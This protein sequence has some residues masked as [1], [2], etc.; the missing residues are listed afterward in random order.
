MVCKHFFSDQRDFTPTSGEGAVFVYENTTLPSLNLYPFPTRWFNFRPFRFQSLQIIPTRVILLI[1]YSFRG[2]RSVFYAGDQ[3]VVY[4][5]VPA[6]KM[7]LVDYL[8]AGAKTDQIGGRFTPGFVVVKEGVNHRMP[9]E[10]R[11]GFGQVDDRVQNR[12]VD[13]QSFGMFQRKISEEIHKSFEGDH[14]I[15]TVVDGGDMF[16]RGA[17]FE[18][19]GAQLSPSG[20]VAETDGEKGAAVYLVTDLA[21]EC[22]GDRRDDAARGEITDQCRMPERSVGEDA[23]R[24]DGGRPHDRQCPANAKRLTNTR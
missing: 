8:A 15:G 17:A 9:G 14:R 3:I 5:L 12:G 2:L 18:P 4:V 11:D 6:V 7:P 24:G 21:A 19:C 22:R 23:E 16:G 13:A 1:G 10:K 20:I